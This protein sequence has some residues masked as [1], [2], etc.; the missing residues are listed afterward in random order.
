MFMLGP[1][2][3]DNEIESYCNYDIKI[4]SIWA[5]WNNDILFLVSLFSEGWMLFSEGWMLFSLLS[6]N[7]D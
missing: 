7:H 2:H 1:S 6:D 4:I 5:I 3:S